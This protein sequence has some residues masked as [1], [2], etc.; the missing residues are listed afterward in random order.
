MWSFLYNNTSESRIAPAPIGI[1]YILHTFDASP[2]AAQGHIVCLRT[3]Q[4]VSAGVIGAKLAFYSTWAPC[5]TYPNST[6]P[7][8]EFYDYNPQTTG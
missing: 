3:K 8:P 7:D 1:P 6:P 4:D 5:T 2:Q